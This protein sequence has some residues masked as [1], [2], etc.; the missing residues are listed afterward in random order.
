MKVVIVGAGNVGYT[1]ARSLSLEGQDIVVVEKNQEVAAKLEDELDVAVVVGN[2]ARPPVLERAGISE[3]CDVDFLIA[4]TD[5]DEVNIMACWVAKKCGVKRAISRARGMEYTD[6]PQ[7]ASFL[8]I[9]VMNSPERSVA[10]DIED[11]LEVN[12]AVHATELFDGRAGS[13]AF[14][15]ETTSPILGKS[16]IQV[17]KENP[18]L[19]SV[20][21]YVERGGKGIVP[22][23]EWVAQEGDLCFLVSFRDMVFKIQELFHPGK[24][25]ALR[26]V[27]IVGG[28]KLGVH[29]AQRL[30]KSYRSIEV[31][32]ID[33]NREKCIR[34]AEE[35]PKVT[36]LWGDGTDEK[37]LKHEGIQDVDGFVAT[38]DNDELNMILAILADRM[39]AR[40]TVAVVRKELYSR[41][42]EDLP[43]DS[44]VNPNDSL[45]SVI[46]R[47]VRYP[48][49]AGTLSMIDRIG[50]EMLEVTVPKDSPVGGK[51]LKDID[52][53]KGIIFAMVK[54]GDSIIVPDGYLVITEGDI[55]SVFATG[56]LL[57]KAIKILGVSQ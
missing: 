32:I 44:V 26:R 3:G 27:M 39:N 49:S 53:P 10:R 21:V 22:S 17:G 33:R 8:G 41:L 29:L 19:S 51:E 43:I 13:Y 31:K 18:D 52:L 1:I 36:V 34:L 14:R 47:H 9:D 56:D 4:C 42:A 2:G 46:L 55:I 28:G 6:T 37:L 48:E 5:H 16:L 15:V 24:D 50:A 40:K 12:A 25:R 30:I 54:R 38:T 45:A 57:P 20:M 23:G 11:L 7:W 35:L